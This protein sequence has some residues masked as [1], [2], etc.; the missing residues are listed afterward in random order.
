M[1]V[2]CVAA[3][4]HKYGREI[5][6]DLLISATSVTISFSSPGMLIFAFY[7]SRGSDFM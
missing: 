4:A 7:A 1:N 5:P 3:T 6:V 2:L